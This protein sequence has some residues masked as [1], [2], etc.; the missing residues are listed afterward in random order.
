MALFE[1]ED[2]YSVGVASIDEQHKKLFDIANRFHEAYDKGH[3]RKI[4]GL[5]FKELITYTQV[6][7]AEEERLM[8]EQ[9]YPDYH[10]HKVNHEKLLGLVLA[11]K[12]RFERDEQGIE[13]QV[14]NFIK[15][16]LNGHI[17]GMDRNYR[18]HVQPGEPR[19]GLDVVA[20]LAPDA[21]AGPNDPKRL[22]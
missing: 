5:I 11:Y 19:M 6:H 10:R 2:I 16:W 13:R 22:H 4:L 3:G 9:N 21:A 17:L 7:F 18:S 12:E 14:M 1:W 8:R 15:T 20:H